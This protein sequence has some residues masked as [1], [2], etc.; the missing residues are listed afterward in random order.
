[1]CIFNKYVPF[2]Y[3]HIHAYAS[4]SLYAYMHIC[5]KA[6]VYNIIEKKWKNKKKKTRKRKNQH[7]F[8]DDLMWLVWVSTANMHTITTTITR[9]ANWKKKT[10]DKN[11]VSV[12]STV[13]FQH[14]RKAKGWKHV[15]KLKERKK[16]EREKAFKNPLDFFHFLFL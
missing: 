6:N 1:M 2:T 10:N 7:C 11:T 16:D 3:M 15:E 12:V 5:T 9:G 14:C 13:N 8:E 4:I